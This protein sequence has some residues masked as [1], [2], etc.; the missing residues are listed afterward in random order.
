MSKNFL[1]ELR[2]QGAC[3]PALEWLE[4]ENFESL[5]AA[6]NA[7][8]RGDWMLWLVG[9]TTDRNDD[10]QLRALTLAKARCAAHALLFMRDERSRN[11]VAVAEQYGLGNATRAELDSAADAAADAA[12]FAAFASAFA[13]FAAS[14]ASAAADAAFATA[15]A[16]F[17]TADA[18]SAS[19]AAHRASLAQ[20]AIKVRSV[21][22]NPPKI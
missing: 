18:A 13:Y 6:W 16:A 3:P 5:D 9:I 14:A 20:S 4:K 17:A 22:P 2:A 10:L 12:A 21:F 8:E 15:D 7:C 1:Y 11:A 19:A